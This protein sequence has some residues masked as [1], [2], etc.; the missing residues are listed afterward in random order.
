[1]AKET[2]KK[3]KHEMKIR[4]RVGSIGMGQNEMHEMLYEKKTKNVLFRAK[5]RNR[6]ARKLC[7]IEIVRFQWNY[8]HVS[9]FGCYYILLCCKGVC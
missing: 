5:R 3:K 1:M 6:L 2:T 7:A 8:I 9:L 4:K